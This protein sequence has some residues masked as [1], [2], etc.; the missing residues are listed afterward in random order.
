MQITV[1][2]ILLPVTI[3]GSTDDRIFNE[4]KTG[5]PFPGPPVGLLERDRHPRMPYAIQPRRRSKVS[6]ARGRMRRVIFQ[7]SS[8]SA[9]YVEISIEAVGR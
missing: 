1:E 2:G 5:R 3:S 9:F 6:A 8:S 4:G 7:K